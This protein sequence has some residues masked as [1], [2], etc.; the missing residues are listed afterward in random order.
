MRAFIYLVR[1]VGSVSL[2]ELSLVDDVVEEL[3]T[4]HD[5]HDDVP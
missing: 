2:G 4:G 1:D 3:A 5:L